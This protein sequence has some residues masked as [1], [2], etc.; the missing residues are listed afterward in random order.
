MKKKSS[1][2]RAALPKTLPVFAG[3]VVL[4]T[5]YGL[6]MNSIGQGIFGPLTSLLVFAGSAQFLQITL[7]TAGAGLFQVA[8]LTFL[9]NFRHFFYGLSMITRYHHA[10]W[11]RWYLMFALTDETYAILASGNEPQDADPIDYYFWVSLLDQFYWVLGT[12]IGVTIGALIKFDTT[13]ADFAM[14]A[15]FVVLAVEQWKSTDRHA[16]ALCGLFCGIVS[17]LIF[18]TDYFLIPALIAIMVF[19]LA[20][21]KHLQSGEKEAE[22]V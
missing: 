1:A 17:L 10:G 4:G 8:V 15:L 9:L 14:T 3:Y 22:S 11:R 19:M 2:F 20:F 16:P 5:A 6:L 13:G 21:R 7:I 18:G 12:V